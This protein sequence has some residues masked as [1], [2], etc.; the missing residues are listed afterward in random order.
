MRDERHAHE[1][2]Q[3]G[4]E[5]ILEIALENEKAGGSTAGFQLA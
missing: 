4:L 3:T 1:A 2:R 5:I